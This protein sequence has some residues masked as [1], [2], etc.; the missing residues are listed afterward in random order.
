MI[1]CPECGKEIAGKEC[2]GCGKDI[3]QES[4]FCMYCGEKVEKDAEDTFNNEDDSDF[5]FEDRIL[6]S[7]GTCTGIIVDGICTECGKKAG[8]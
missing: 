8:E 3:L 7:D 1:K 2:T 4:I 6:C 5:D